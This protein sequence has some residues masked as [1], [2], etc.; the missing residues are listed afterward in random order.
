VEEKREDMEVLMWGFGVKEREIRVLQMMNTVPTRYRCK[1]IKPSCVSTTA[2]SC[3][4][5]KE[6]REQEEGCGGTLADTGL[7]EVRRLF[8]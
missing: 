1:C 7:R 4:A 3:R 5:S 2:N 6:R 8:Q